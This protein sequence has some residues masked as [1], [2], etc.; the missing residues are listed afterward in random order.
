MIIGAAD[1]RS[2]SILLF[3]SLWFIPCCLLGQPGA[4]N[5][6]PAVASKT[7]LK[8]LMNQGTI[9]LAKSCHALRRERASECSWTWL[10]F[11]VSK[12]RKSLMIWHHV[13]RQK[14][15]CSAF[16]NERD[17]LSLYARHSATPSYHFIIYQ[18]VLSLQANTGLT[19]I[20]C[21]NAD[22]GRVWDLIVITTTI[23]V[24]W[25]GETT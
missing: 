12:R 23:T 1:L 9:T 6:L 11:L 18:S 8:G 22:S 21:V 3:V 24:S 19:P 13:L 5:N 7:Q 15:D 10:S 17:T 20:C 2:G 16:L 4:V 14:K 25:T